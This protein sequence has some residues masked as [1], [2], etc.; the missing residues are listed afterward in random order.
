MPRRHSDLSGLSHTFSVEAGQ[1]LLLSEESAARMPTRMRLVTILP[2]HILALLPQTNVVKGAS[3]R[4]LLL[5]FVVPLV[6]QLITTE[7]ALFGIQM[8][9]VLVTIFTG[10]IGRHA[11]PVAEIVLAASTADPILAHMDSSCR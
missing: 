3:F 5:L 10:V 1:A 11:T 7:S 6:N 4:P 2:D 9:L 8:P